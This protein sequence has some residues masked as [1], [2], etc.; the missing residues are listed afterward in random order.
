MF[1]K[2]SFKEDVLETFPNIIPLPS[3]PIQDSWRL[4]ARAQR[5]AKSR[6]DHLL[7]C[8]ESPPGEERPNRRMGPGLPE[9]IC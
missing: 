1:R 5:L 8:Y 6:P 3:N 9:K 7:A 2:L 4:R